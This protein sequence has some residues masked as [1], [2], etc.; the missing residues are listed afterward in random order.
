MM[1]P[2]SDDLNHILSHTEG[3][4]EELRGLR[5]FITGGTGFF[6]C[7]HLESL[8]W[9]DQQLGLN[10]R[11]VVLT[12][13]AEAFRRRVPRLAT[14]PAVDLYPGDVRSFSFPEGEF[15]HI[16]HAAT[17][18][19][20]NLN[21][22]DPS[23]MLDTIVSG[24]RRTLD[25]AVRCGA[26]KFLLTSS[27]AVYGQQPPELS[28]LPEDYPGAPDLT[29]SRSTY[30]EG[31]RMAELLCTLYSKEHGL[32]T[33]V[34]RCF[35]F[36]GPYL[37]LNVHFAVGNFIRD[38]IAGGPIRVNGDG[39]PR[40][41]YLYAA[42]LMIWLWSILFRGQTRIPYNT[43]SEASLSI[44]EL[45]QTVAGIFSPQPRVMIAKKADPSKIPEQYVP[46]TRRARAELG[47]N[48]W[49]DLPEAI[50]RTVRWHRTGS[51]GHPHEQHAQRRAQ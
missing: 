26:R 9:A 1:N 36:V 7:W 45:A 34:A 46:S 12:R 28:H 8:L 3:L 17:E 6:G 19:S 23:S 50:R 5:I 11:A 30:A 21:Q 38:G 51:A 29:D 14:H 32:E 13:N 24:T 43:G 42:D 44:A 22:E 48:Q 4:W 16:I 25:F 39:T 27:G 10:V 33:K 41:S 15:S 40:R 37:P 47:L 20:S 31:K 2:L 35:A 49:V 18:S